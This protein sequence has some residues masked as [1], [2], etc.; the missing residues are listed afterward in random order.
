[1]PSRPFRA[2]FAVAYAAALAAAVTTALLDVLITWARAGE[3][4][5]AG[6][7]LSSALA[8]LGLYG[9][10]AALLAL[11]EAIVAGGILATVDVAGRGREFLAG[12]RHDA[13]R[14]RAAAAALLAAAAAVAVVGIIVFAFD[15]AVALE[16]NAR[17]NS[18]ITTA[19]VAMIAV[20]LGALAWFP[21][22]RLCRRL[23]SPLPRPRL[24]VV[25]AALLL[26]VLLALVAALFSVDWRVIDFGPA[27][28]L[29]T[30]FAFQ[31]IFAILLRKHAR[32]GILAGGW[33]ALA[34]CFF[35]TWTSFGGSPR[36]V[37]FAGE[38]SMG[39]KV[40]LRI[41]RRFADRDHDGY[42]A[43]SA[44]A[45]A[46]IATRASTPAPTRSAA[47]ASTRTATAPTRPSRS[48]APSPDDRFGGGGQ[49]QMS[50]Q[51]PGH[52]HR[53]AARR[54]HQPEDGAATS[55]S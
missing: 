2:A 52:H 20:P 50:R 22:Y 29:L 7:L 17:R 33:I 25:A 10:L 6:A 24:F 31:I 55:T 3:P 42:A 39:E 14:D 45:T 46:T 26:V 49:A 5:G 38:E 9:A 1:M 51:P 30:F 15:A 36:A 40:L 35:V 54:S 13:D 21:L 19:M 27:E 12:V 23:V 4:V 53:H 28:S 18:A 48:R 32:I 16:M 43:G 37:S 11:G 44:A 8:A 41:A 34:V 47:T